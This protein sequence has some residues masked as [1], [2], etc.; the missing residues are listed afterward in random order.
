VSHPGTRSSC[1]LLQQS[2]VWS[3]M[4]SDVR[5]FCRACVDCQRS[6]VVRHL[7][8]PPATV[9]IPSRRFSAIN[10]DLVGPLPSTGGEGYRYILSIIDRH[11]RWFELM[12]LVSMDTASVCRALIS[13]WVSRYGVP[14]IIYSDRGSQFISS[15]W[16]SLGRLLGFSPSTTT[17][18]NPKCNGLV[19]R[20][21]RSI[22]ASLR[23]RRT[24]NWVDD[25]PWVALGL[26]TAPRDDSGVSAA[27]RVFGLPLVLP[28]T[29]LDAPEAEDQ[30]LSSR[31]QQLLSS[32]PLTPVKTTNST[33]VPPMSW[34]FLRVDSHKPPLAQLYEGPYRVLRQTRQTAV[35]QMGERKEKVN[36]GRLKPYL[37]TEDPVPAQPRRRGRPRK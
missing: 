35:L 28:G 7:R 24:V 6:K 21:H 33:T 20:L 5:D 29:F 22:K 23:A 25:L 36:I 31:F 10:I 27:E 26:R 3:R 17:S 2:F 16:S 8:P 4:S 12:P 15:L 11:S 37:S 34:A 18:Y 19:E 9:P 14:S 30:T 32:V 1:R 13:G